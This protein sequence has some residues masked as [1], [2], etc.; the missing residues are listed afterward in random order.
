MN[1]DDAFEDLGEILYESAPE[2]VVRHMAGNLAPIQEMVPW[3]EASD[4]SKDFWCNV[5][6][7]AIEWT[8][9][10]YKKGHLP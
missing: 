3:S 6:Y 5:A 2:Y 1:W 8:V 9:A 4:Q 7:K 10:E